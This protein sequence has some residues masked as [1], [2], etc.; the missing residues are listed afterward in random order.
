MQN[1]NVHSNK[2]VSFTLCFSVNLT[3]EVKISHKQIPWIKVEC[4]LKPL[5]NAVS[6]NKNGV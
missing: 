3:H 5:I 6:Q 1:S 4:T 2:F